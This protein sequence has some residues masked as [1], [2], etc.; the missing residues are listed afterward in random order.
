[1][2]SQVLEQS[3]ARSGLIAVWPLPP[4]ERMP[5]GVRSAAEQYVRLGQEYRAAA[6]RRQE[7]EHEHRMAE[8]TDSQ[9]YAD[10]LR[11]GRKDPGPVNVRK[12]E[13]EQVA[14]RR[15]REALA[16]AVEDAYAD[17]L[18]AV[19]QARKSWREQL[20]AEM[21]SARSAYRD[22]IQAL[23]AARDAFFQIA[24]VLGWLSGFPERPAF[25][26]HPVGVHK[27][28]QS[29]QRVEEALLFETRS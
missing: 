16:L 19:D 23:A 29:W 18:R 25:A 2:A 12:V 20:D 21:A 10:A 1:M 15:K 26:Y 17:L 14:V 4:A 6:Q 7:L 28:E 27:L 8:R 22:S 13:A 24:A 11:E 9:V 5:E 3:T